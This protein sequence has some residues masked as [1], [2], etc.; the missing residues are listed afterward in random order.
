[1]R[2]CSETLESEMS[3]KELDL[4]L[5][6]IVEHRGRNPHLEIG[7][8]AGG[9]LWKMMSCFEGNN[10]PNFVVVDPMKYFPNQYEVVRHNLSLHE[11]DVERVDFRRTSSTDALIGAKEFNEV[12]S[13]IL[14]DARHKIRYVMDDLRWGELLEEGGV[15][16]L[17]DESEACPGVVNCLV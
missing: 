5:K 6:V 14:I 10:V 7:T 15:L 12:F 2:S 13:F 1:M 16:C 9:T 4:L 11:V 17:H 3:E 8:A